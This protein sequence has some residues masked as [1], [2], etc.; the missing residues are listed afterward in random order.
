M[1][2]KQ[3]TF[4]TFIFDANF[5]ITLKHVKAK[6]YLDRLLDVRDELKIKFY[7]SKQVY[8]EI[9]FVH[10]EPEKS[11][12]TN[13]VKI[14]NVSEE[15]ILFVKRDLSN[16]GINEPRH[17]QD[18][19]LSLVSL[20]RKIRNPNTKVCIVSDDYKLN[21]NVKLLESVGTRNYD[22]EFWP[23]SAFLLYLTRTTGRTD[24]QDYYKKVRDKT[25]KNRLAYYLQKHSSKQYNV[26]NKL[27]WL[28][29]KA[30]SVT[31]EG[32]FKLTGLKQQYDST[33]EGSLSPVISDTFCN[34]IDDKSSEILQ[35]SSKYI[36][37]LKIS[38]TDLEK[39][40]MMIPLLNEIIEG[41]EYIKIA[42]S[43]LKDDYDAIGTLRI[44]KDNLMYTL[45]KAASVLN[46]HHY[47]IFQKLVCSELSKCEFLRAFL[48]IGTGD[49][50][51][52]LEALDA[53]AM[54]ATMANISNTVLSINYLK[55]LIYLFNQF[56][57]ES[58]DQFYFT[59]NLAVNYSAPPLLELKCEIGHAI[60]QFLSGLEAEALDS[61]DNISNSIEKG[62]LEDALIVFQELGD[63]FYAMA[64]PRIAITLY[65][66]ALECAVDDTKLEWRIEIILDKLKRAYMNALLESSTN[67]ES[68]T[69]ID[70]IINHVYKLKNINRYNQ[71]IAK[72]SRFHQ[73][74]YEDFP[75]YTSG[76]TKVSYFDIDESIR[77]SFDVVDILKDEKSS[78]TV[79]IAYNKE[80][81]LIGFRIN[82][83][84]Q[85]Q[86]IPENYTTRLTK[87]AKVRILKPSDALKTKYLIRAL[88]CVD[89][90]SHLYI[91]R[92]IPVFFAQMNI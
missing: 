20:S 88:I 5:F 70:S 32:G 22:M 83:D 78:N 43:S 35:I 52:A 90:P 67:I 57:I 29:E 23:I 91:N 8:D 84:K 34:E 48:F 74:F 42:K 56:Y 79:L 3:S 38:S 71:E 17:A 30:I 37:K 63:Y 46:K 7:T 4:N 31:E 19:D 66:E 11:K 2:K 72:L 15:E 64:N 53:T 6:N 86:G 41:R 89:D 80:I 24:L 81:G 44:A 40:A 33:K 12:F 82:L 50:N 51:A 21:D 26:Q 87:K 45:Q 69:N 39:V 36:Q 92:N 58:I 65:D 1:T 85:L 9:L 18:P 28:I 59:H 75:I 73:I 10:Q 77:E 54:F 25:L 62:N 16:L 47:D 13:L 60:A 14:T 68:P 61:I 27:M 76:S 49:I 55:A